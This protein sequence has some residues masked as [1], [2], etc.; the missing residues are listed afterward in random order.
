MTEKHEDRR[1]FKRIAFDAKTELS[2][3]DRTWAVQ[4]IDL[5]LKGLLIEKPSPWEGDPT[6]RFMVDI[7]L[8]AGIDVVME[9]RLPTTITIIS[10][11]SAT[12]SSST[13]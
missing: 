7:Q 2:Q 1:R 5:S 11:S 8:Q 6:A 3:G 12:T 10:G 9:V 4:L 13:R